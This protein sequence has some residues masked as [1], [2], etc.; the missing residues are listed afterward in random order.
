MPLQGLEGGLGFHIPGSLCWGL[1]GSFWKAQPWGL[2]QGLQKCPGWVGQRKRPLGFAGELGVGE[3]GTGD[4]H[5]RAFARLHYCFYT[6]LGSG[7]R[8]SRVL[9]LL[10]Q[11]SPA[12]SPVTTPDSQMTLRQG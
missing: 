10:P 3:P 7:L 1:G 5:P 12:S 2:E 8:A 6:V 11:G 4:F 9:A